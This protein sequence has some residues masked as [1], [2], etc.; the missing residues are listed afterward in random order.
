MSVPSLV[1]MST[2]ESLRDKMKNIK[3]P[4]SL[5]HSKKQESPVTHTALTLAIGMSAASYASASYATEEATQVDSEDK[6]EVIEV[7]GVKEAPYKAIRSG[8]L[9]R[10]V[11]LSESPITMTILTQTQLLD[12]GKTDLKEILSSQAG[13]TL[14]TGEN[15]I[16][17]G[18]RYIIR[19]HEARS[20]IFVDGIRDPGMTIRESFATEQIEITKGPSSTFAGRGSSGGA[21]NGITKQ[22][23]LNQEFSV[24]T[25]SVGT[26]DMHRFTADINRTLSDEV[27]VRANLLYSDTDVPDRGPAARKRVGGLFSTLWQ[28]TADLKLA[29]DYYHLNADNKPDAGSFWDSDKREVVS[30]VP[31]YLQDNDFLDTEVNIFTFK[32]HYHISDSLQLQNSTRYGQTENGYVIT[33]ARL[34]T[35]DASDTVA[36]GQDTF[37][38]STHQGWQEI[39][40]FVNQT[41]LLWDTDF[42]GIPHQ[43]V[44][45]FE[46]SNEDVKNGFYDTVDTAEKNCLVQFRGNPSAQYC[47]TDANGDVLSNIGSLLG[48]TTS[49]GEQDSNFDMVTYSA[50]LMDT[51]E[52]GDW[53]AF[54]GVRYDSFDYNN[55]TI[56]RGGA[57]EYNFSDHFWN[58]HAS[59]V[60]SIGDNGNVYLTY[61]TATNINGGES[62][63]G[64]NCGYGGLCGTPEQATGS[65][66]E[67]VK[68]IELGTKWELFD[69]R[70]LATA[71]IFQTTKSDVM[72]NVG[73][74]YDNLGTLNT[75]KNRVEGIELSLT[76]A[77]TDKLSVQ[78]SAALMDSEVLE[79]FIPENEGRSLAA[80]ADNSYYLQLRYE[81]TENFAFGSSF[82]YKSEMYS[83]QPDTAAQYLDDIGE[84]RIVVP[85]YNTIDLFINYRINDSMNLRVNLRNVTD[86][87]Y[88]T[89]SYGP[90]KFM[91]LGDARH[92]QATLSW[93]F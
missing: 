41:N 10:T 7:Y 8:D 4:S 29:V 93:L 77:I 56:G 51:I 35:R 89:A 32:A 50:Y 54:V 46:Y 30:N 72:E 36:S 66:P 43:V 17:F 47:G 55:P 24:A 52:F 59:L 23:N 12:S 42:N 45:G 62:D 53:T 21:V 81:V 37:T 67:Q 75:G 86:E 90:G 87:E 22:A 69:D 83:G 85:S 3:R 6:T 63:V 1:F 44:A 64:S 57:A 9:R 70:L 19:G 16:S 71:A 34:S 88:W 27:A 82:T 61:S 76:G 49:K 38:L 74:N 68:N 39:E 84:Y 18:D 40:Y 28:T 91:Y 26:D 80:F 11:E 31:V 79:S 33:G 13:I 20:D 58:G 92:S 78:F 25:A 65:D 14:G 5:R 60:K 2:Y 48:R 15:G 73:S